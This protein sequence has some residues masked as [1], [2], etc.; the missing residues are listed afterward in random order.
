MKKVIFLALLTLIS[1]YFKAQD[2]SIYDIKKVASAYYKSNNNG[3]ELKYDKIIPVTKNGDTLFYVFSF[4]QDGFVMVS[5]DRAAPP[6]L[7]YTKKGRFQIFE[8]PPGLLYLIEKYKYLITALK[9]TSTVPSKKISDQCSFMALPNPADSYIDICIDPEKI[10]QDK[11]S[12]N[13][14]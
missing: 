8:M 13:R 10:I 7:G 6:I 11:L 14:E 12:L 5:N 9:S 1:F 3:E 4:I 2:V